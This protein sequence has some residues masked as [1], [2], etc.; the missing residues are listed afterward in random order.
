MAAKGLAS[1]KSSRRIGPVFWGW[2]KM[3]KIRESV[4]LKGTV[5]T[6]CSTKWGVT[7]VPLATRVT[8]LTP[9]GETLG[10][11]V[12]VIC[13]QPSERID[14]V[15]LTPGKGLAPYHGGWAESPCPRQY[16]LVKGS[17]KR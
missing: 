9:S 3:L 6:D 10:S 16:R 15:W 14:L 17:P 11:S 2:I 13:V 8:W 7:V 1:P 4:S 5:P 12:S